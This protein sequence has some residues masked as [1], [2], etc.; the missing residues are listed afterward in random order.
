MEYFIARLLDGENDFEIIADKFGNRFN[1][2]ISVQQL[3]QF[4]ASLISRGLIENIEQPEYPRK[5]RVRKSLF[6]RILF[7]KVKA[8]NP[9]KFIARTYNYARPLYSRSAIYLYIFL[10]ILAGSI[11]LSNIDD[12]K[13]QLASFF[14]PEIILLVWV[15]IFFVTVIHELSHTY[16][17]RLYGG[18]VTDMGFLLL[19]LQPCFYSNVSDAYLFPERKKRLAV[20]AAGIISQIVVWALATIVWRITSMDNIINT[21]AFIIIGLSFIG[22]T[23][24]L[25]PLIKLDGYYF[26]VDFWEIP[27]LRQKAF[28][29]LRQKI[30]GLADGEPQLAATPREKRIFRYYGLASLMYSGALITYIAYRVGKYLDRQIGSFGVVILVLFLLYLLGDA[31]KKGR[32]FE[33]VYNQRGAI[34]KPGRLIVGGV[35]LMFIVLALIFIQ[36]P[37]KITNDCQVLPLERVSLRSSTT[38]FA[39]LIVERADERRVLKQYQLVGQ[40]YGVLSILPA[41]KV[42]DTVF[43][44]D[45]IAGIHSNV[46][47][48]E[49]LERYA[50]LQ[51]S[52]K[53]LD[54][55]EK[56]PQPEEI[57]QTE[58]II[59]QVRSK[60]NQSLQDLNRA[61]SLFVKGGI[62]QK[63]LEDK[64]TDSQVLKSELDF[65]MNQLTLL[66]RGAR[67]EEIDMAKAQVEQLQAKLKHL[68]SQLEQTAI[69]SPIEGI[70][71]QVNNGDIII[72]IARIDT[73]KVKISVPEK[74]ISEVSIGNGVIMKARSYPGLT[75]IGQVKR[76]DPIAFEDMRGRSIISVTA[77]AANPEGLLK[78][79]MTGKAKINCGDNPLY[80]II[81]W[82]V[83]RYLRIEFWSWW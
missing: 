21:I 75:Y 72:S 17:C 14:R 83:V 58:D 55:L 34:L 51:E 47:E 78:P 81:L 40:D 15:T 82:R 46:Y 13:Y 59:S 65:Y 36:L 6:S 66:R 52:K 80:K 74:E 8:I 11:T 1:V 35:I 60:Y 3:E 62:S 37:L 22:I 64:R 49:K 42:G 45:L 16:R 68:E 33:I 9:E 69:E 7:I 73:V 20:T 57:K 27:N 70:V 76:I 32:I 30:V 4:T 18:K 61:E 38:G 2:R 50:N 67:P 63:E 79:G 53:Q 26:L 56:G 5:Q 43:P 39:D 23:F 10:T 77:L 12:M 71:T 25:N 28:R 44:G 24:N 41:L 54:L 48:S 19:Y 29:Y 31:M